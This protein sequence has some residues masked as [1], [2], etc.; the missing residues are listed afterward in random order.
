MSADGQRVAYFDTQSKLYVWD[1]DLQANIY[2]NS[3]TG[4]TSAG[5]SQDGTRLLYLYSGN[6]YVRDLTAKT[7]LLV[8][9]STVPIKGSSQWS[10]DGRYV[11]F[12]TVT[13]LV[14]GDNNGTNDVYLLD[15]QTGTLTLVSA[16][17]SG[18]AEHSR[19]GFGFAGGQH[20]RTVRGVPHFCHRRGVRDCQPSFLDCV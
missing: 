3:T 6:L 14:A 18:T 16:N 4:L 9:P 7:N 8:C 13:N 15:Y 11:A 17:Q 10:G 5:P 20:G 12:V 19:R 1:A 2:T